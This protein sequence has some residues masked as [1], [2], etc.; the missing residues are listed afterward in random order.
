M[1]I[2]LREIKNPILSYKVGLISDSIVIALLNSAALLVPGV[3]YAILLGVS[4]ALWNILPYMGGIIS[5]ADTMR[6]TK[7][8]VIPVG[9]KPTAASNVS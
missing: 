6:C 5:I 8:S 1:S 2:V 4:S 9:A 3:L 7:S